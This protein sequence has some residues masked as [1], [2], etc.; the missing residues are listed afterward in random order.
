MLWHSIFL[1]FWREK[2]NSEFRLLA[3]ALA[4]AVFS[5]TTLTCLT[6]SFSATLTG[7][8]G[9]LLGADIILESA[10]PL[11][12]SLMEF[13]Q[14]QG[15]KTAFMVEFFTMLTI[16]G[17]MQLA[18]VMACDA[19]YPLRGKLMVSKDTAKPKSAWAPPPIGEVWVDQ[20]LALKFNVGSHDEATLGYA[21]LNITGIVHQ[22][23]V[24]VSENA[25]LAPVVYINAQDIVTLGV[26]Q[27]G[28]RATYHLMLS[29]NPQALEIFRARFW[30][31]FPEVTWVTPQ[32]GRPALSRTIEYGKRY[33]AVILL[34]QVL[35]AGLAIAICAGQYT[36]R[37]QK[38]VALL[39]C[40]GVS[41]STLI[42]LQMGVLLILAGCVL[43][44]SVGAGYLVA[45]TLIALSQHLGFYA[46]NL[47]WQGAGLGALTGI[48]LLLGFAL[49]P[50]LRLKEISPVR[51]VQQNGS[52]FST[53]S[54][55]SVAFAIAALAALFFA[56]LGE[57][58]VTLHLGG[59][60]ILAGAGIF[61]LAYGLWVILT[62]LAHRGPLAW[63]FGVGY[64]IRH[65]WQ[66]I[67]QWLVFTLVLMLMILV[68]VVQQDFIP[69]WQNQL[70]ALTPNYFLV[71]VQQEKMPLL[72]NWFVGQGIQE[73]KFYPIVR[74]RMSHVNGTAIN[75]HNSGPKTHPGLD[76]PIN[77][78]WG[79]SLPADNQVT[80]GIAWEAAL[81]GQPV[82]SVEEGFGKRQSLKLND[83]VTFQISEE[84]IT[85]KI[86]QFRT[87][88]WESFKP[89]FFVIFP[90]KV[91]DKFPHT[92]I[93]SFYLPPAQK[94]ILKDL[95]Q[96]FVEISVLDIDFFLGAVRK[97]ITKIT[98]G[99]QILLGLVFA[100]GVVIMY[101]SLLS[102]L[103]ERL[104]ESAMLQILGAGK[105]FVGK[106]LLV[107]FCI[108]GF[109]SGSIASVAA[110]F[111]AYDLGHNAF[112]VPFSLSLKWVV[113]GSLCG[114]A[115]VVVL[116]L[117]GARQVF[118][119]SPLWLLREKGER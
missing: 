22:R 27:P 93:T 33:L 94:I 63:R 65:K 92:Y 59:Q 31:A 1:Q 45:G 4:L 70:P 51:I 86:V 46:V 69:L 42:Q 75:A 91:I 9:D 106:V 49:P 110:L 82:I 119:V 85:G 103:K 105:R 98:F 89:N 25:A 100:L 32:S 23:P 5:V 35:L 41:G 78:T 10:T 64:L 113:I 24:A 30:N 18:D 117:I 61:T 102:T 29:G 16:K 26:L 107:E 14:A 71:N 44:F 81:A 55:K 84:F 68:Q 73:V 96:K 104:Q 66:G 76:R 67:T 79:D 83:T 90:D 20:D 40:F 39:R 95:V 15:L 72:K 74:G 87:V 54:L 108:L 8:A 101:A 34:I 17:E 38:K 112:S 21:K 28:S 109:F 62:P 36:L 88:E 56:F 60:L 12:P 50:I 57:H 58:D 52:N 118:Q 11:D 48:T 99:L 19:P 80:S 116:G 6:Q 114:T 77:L 3:F 13:A 43:T 53:A 97:M 2:H 111:I 115:A 37:Q 7:E 47:N